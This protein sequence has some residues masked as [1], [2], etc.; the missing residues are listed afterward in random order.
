M[1]NTTEDIDAALL[2]RLQDRMM[3]RANTA[4]VFIDEHG[5]GTLRKNKRLGMAWKQQYLEERV[6]FEFGWEFECLPRTRITTGVAMSEGDNKSVTEAGW[7]ADRLITLSLFPRD[8]YTVCYLIV[9][10]Q[11]G[12]RREG[13]GV[14]CDTDVSFVP[15][16]YVVFA[17]LAEFSA[18]TKEW[19]PA[20]NP[21]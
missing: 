7:H 10:Y 2:K 18:A 16:G 17:I 5:S 15:E 19:L 21:C 14:T 8:V 3:L 1:M 13:I 9:E 11:D 6:A 12:T 4:E 20:V